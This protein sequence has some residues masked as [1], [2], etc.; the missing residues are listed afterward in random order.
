[1][2][3]FGQ[4]LLADWDIV[5]NCSGSHSDKILGLSHKK[6]FI[7]KMWSHVPCGI[8][9]YQVKDLLQLIILGTEI[10]QFAQLSRELW[11][12]YWRG[13]TVTSKMRK[14]TC[15]WDCL[16]IMLFLDLLIIFLHKIP[17]LEVSELN[18]WITQKISNKWF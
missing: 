6:N 16:K 13:V 10:F 18:L 15:F 5:W 4:R 2:L 8:W 11:A 3:S 7:K 14:N 12:F 17:W 1:M 9:R